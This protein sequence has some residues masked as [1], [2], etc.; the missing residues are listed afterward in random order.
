AMARAPKPKKNFTPHIYTRKELDNI[1]GACDNLRCDYIRKD[2][3]YI[4]MPALIRFLFGTGVRIGEALD[5]RTDDINLMHNHLTLRDTKNGKE[6]LLPFSESMAI[7]LRE[8]SKHR[9]RLASQKQIGFF[10]ITARGRK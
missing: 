2:S 9:D 3:L 1:F 4:V 5:L 6:R 7:V 8:Y 10:F